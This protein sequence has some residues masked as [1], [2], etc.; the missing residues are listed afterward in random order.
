MLIKAMS[1]KQ[2]AWEGRGAR[3]ARS[4]SS[5]PVGSARHISLVTVNRRP[6]AERQGPSL[7]DLAPKPPAAVASFQVLHLEDVLNLRREGCRV[8]FVFSENWPAC[9]PLALSKS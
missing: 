8:C 5:L 1:L 6:E 7:Q 2:R 3:E 4:T 9:L